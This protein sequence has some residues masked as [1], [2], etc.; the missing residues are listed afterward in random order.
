MLRSDAAW[1]IDGNTVTN[2]ERASV[3]M[4][5]AFDESILADA[6]TRLDVAK[7]GFTAE[8]ETVQLFNST[9]D[10]I[11]Y[12]ETH[13]RSGAADGTGTAYSETVY[14]MGGTDDFTVD[15]TYTD[16]E[17]KLTIPSVAWEDAKVSGPDPAASEAA[18][19]T[20]SG[21]LVKPASGAA[22]TAIAKSAVSTSYVA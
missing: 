9:Q 22:I 13:Y 2:V 6:V 12:K 8:V 7:L 20:R 1:T 4:R 10:A 14:G 21:F 18:R 16:R 15:F 17:A 19:L 3:T 5:W 11:D